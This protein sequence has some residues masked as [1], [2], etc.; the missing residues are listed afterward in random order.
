MVLS[1]VGDFEANSKIEADIEVAPVLIDYLRNSCKRL[2]SILM[3][4]KARMG[5]F[6]EDVSRGALMSMFLLSI[7]SFIGT[8]GTLR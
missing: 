6:S 7:V 8:M 4:A 2:S 3:L 1:H 5:R